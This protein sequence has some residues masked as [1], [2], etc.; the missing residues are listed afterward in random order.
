MPREFAVL[1][2]QRKE[3]VKIEEGDLVLIWSPKTFPDIHDQ[4]CFVSKILEKKLGLERFDDKSDLI[5]DI[6]KL[7]F[8]DSNCKKKHKTIRNSG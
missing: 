8:V 7:S 3:E 4:I 6:D 1:T 5:Y 2:F